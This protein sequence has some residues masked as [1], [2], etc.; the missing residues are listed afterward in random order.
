M[1]ATPLP[2]DAETLAVHLRAWSILFAR[3][4]APTSEV[5]QQLIARLAPLYP[6]GA[7]TVNR[8]LCELLVFLKWPEIVARTLPLI[9]A[10]VSQ[11][12][13]IHYVHALLRY[14][15][16]W[17]PDQRRTL[18]QWFPDASQL[19]GGHRYEEVLTNMQQDFL[20]GFTDTERNALATEIAALAAPAPADVQLP[21]RPLV[22]RWT[23]DELLPQLDLTTR[24]HDPLTG[25]RMLTEAGCL[26]CHRWEQSGA[27][28]GPDLT[29]VGKRYSVQKIAESI[30]EPSK[31]IDPK[32]GTT[33]YLLADGRIVI[34]RAAGVNATELTVETNSLTRETVKIARDEIEESRPASVSPMP[35]GLLDSFTADEIRELL[36]FLRTGSQP[37]P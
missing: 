11:E 37:S 4:P 25:K 33:Q 27:A 23:L 15:G 5:A 20:D 18:L 13:E 17:T 2:D 6:H 30:I 34:G 19:G 8:D 16:E 10:A 31:V 14:A 36:A 29:S 12:D 1:L 3:G 7:A 35:A 9:T 28:V 24:S 21:Q 32:Y 22:Q 26:K